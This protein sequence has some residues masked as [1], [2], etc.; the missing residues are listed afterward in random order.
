MSLRLLLC[1]AALLCICALLALAALSARDA[2]TLAWQS[3]LEQGLIIGIQYPVADSLMFG[4]FSLI[5][6]QLHCVIPAVSSATLERDMSVDFFE[7]TCLKQ[8][9][10]RSTS[11]TI[12]LMTN[13]QLKG[14]AR[15]QCKKGRRA[16]HSIRARASKFNIKSTSSL[17]L[18]FRTQAGDA[19]CGDHAHRI[20]S[21]PSVRATIDS[22][23]RHLHSFTFSDL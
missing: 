2:Q 17:S 3:A 1:A 20:A 8:Y 18:H 16:T 23:A 11:E 15:Q 6:A 7:T 19:I 12:A 5:D 13:G 14:T 4:A 9:P 22:C 21:P 10:G